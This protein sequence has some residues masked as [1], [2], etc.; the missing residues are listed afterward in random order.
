MTE[1]VKE[2]FLEFEKLVREIEDRKQALQ[3]KRKTLIGLLSPK[4]QEYGSMIVAGENVSTIE[5]EIQKLESDIAN[6]SR[7]LKAFESPKHKRTDKI[8]KIAKE[9]IK[10]N[11]NEKQK[12]QSE[13]EGHAD[14]LLKI[15]SEFLLI[16]SEMG[17]LQKS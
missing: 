12:L 11:D 4:Q 17:E 6:V 2:K 3:E 15:K 13:Y 8:V 14:E 1:K 16:V 10:N 5:A 9:I 7:S